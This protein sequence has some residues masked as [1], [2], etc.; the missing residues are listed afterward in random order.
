MLSIDMILTIAMFTVFIV[1]VIWAWSPG[2]KKEFDEAKQLALEPDDIT[3]E[4]ATRREDLKH[5]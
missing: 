1:I 5:G 2:R 3:L 4:K